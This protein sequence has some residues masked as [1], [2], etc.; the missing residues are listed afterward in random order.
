M[1]KL[2]FTG[3]H[4]AGRVYEIALEKT[5]VG[6]GEHNTLV[7]NHPSVSL[8]HCEILLHGSEVIVRDLGTANDTYVNGKRLHR[9]QYQMKSGQV[10]QFGSVQARLDLE[11]P[12][13]E[14]TDYDETA[15]FDAR[16]I[17][18]EQR[19]E[20]KAPKPA[21]AA[22]TFGTS[23][24]SNREL[25]TVLLPPAVPSKQVSTPPTPQLPKV[26]SRKPRLRILLVVVLVLALVFALVLLWKP[27]VMR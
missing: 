19:R 25:K 8:L 12:N 18:R 6:R 17:T 9:E 5:T 11:L 22:A 21:S 1:P 15:V 27:Y 23:A 20:E 26:S 14:N 24:D 13:S 4:F 2:I 3:E 7:L 16:R 10:I